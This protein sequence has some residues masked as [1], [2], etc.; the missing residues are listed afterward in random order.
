MGTLTMRWPVPVRGGGGE[1][2][3]VAAFTCLDWLVVVA[4]M[5]PA[6]VGGE[7]D[8]IHITAASNLHRLCFV[9]VVLVP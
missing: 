8:G 6:P 3:L 9:T 1:Q 7:S 2:S 4:G 5:W